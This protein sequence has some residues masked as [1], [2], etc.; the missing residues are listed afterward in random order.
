MVLSDKKEAL[1][2]VEDKIT[3]TMNKVRYDKNFQNPILRLG[4]TGNTYNSILANSAIDGIKTHHRAVKKDYKNIEDAIIQSTNFLKEDLK[5][6]IIAYEGVDLQEISNYFDL[7]N[8][9]FDTELCF[10]FEEFSQVEE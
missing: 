10:D 6:E 4:K 2:V 7:E 9:L 1:D 8:I 5:A 3:Q